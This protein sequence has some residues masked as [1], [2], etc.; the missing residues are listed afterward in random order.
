M[1]ISSLASYTEIGKAQEISNEIRRLNKQLLESQNLA[2]VYN[3][4]EQLLNIPITNVRY[5]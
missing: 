4:R 1:L 3:N 5:F 2:A